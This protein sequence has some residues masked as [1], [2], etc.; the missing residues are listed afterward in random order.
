MRLILR[1]MHLHLSRQCDERCS[2]RNKGCIV[3]GKY[4]IYYFMRYDFAY[5]GNVTRIRYDRFNVPVSV[6]D[7]NGVV[8]EYAYDDAGL[9]VSV[10]RKDG[11]EVLASLSVAYDGCGRPVSYTDQDGLVTSFSRDGFGRVLRER[12]PDG[13]ETCYTYD[14]L[15]RRTSVLDENGHR[16]AFEDLAGLASPRWSCTYEDAL[17]RTVCETRPDFR[18]RSIY[19]IKIFW[20]ICGAVVFSM[21]ANGVTI[22]VVELGNEDKISWKREVL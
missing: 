6:T 11:A 16:I 21:V 4:E 17:G 3:T 22:Y 8:T 15:G 9:V 2:W 1:A 12:F 14:A 10:V 13:S 20:Q 18:S 7:A 19:D 5:L